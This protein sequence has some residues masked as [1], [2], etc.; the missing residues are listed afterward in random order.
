M[1][2]AL[3]PPNATQ[4]K[5][6]VAELIEQSTNL[7]VA[8]KYLWDPFKC[9]EKL[10]PWLAWAYSVDRWDPNWPINTQR[11][12]ISQS[13]E[14]HQ[15][16]GTPFAIQQALV[17]LGITAVQQEWWE[18][19]QNSIPGTFKVLALLNDNLTNGD[20][21]L[22]K[23]MLELVTEVIHQSKRGTAHFDVELGLKFDESNGLAAA[24]HS[25][26]SITDH[27]ITINGISPGAAGMFYSSSLASHQIIA[28]DLTFESEFRDEINAE[29]QAGVNGWA[30]NQVLMFDFTITGIMQ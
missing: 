21:I 23:E 17:S 2:K 28:A 4:F 1:M 8:I 12:V 16:K 7:E 10:L 6:D 30:T 20:G 15:H 29:I 11:N 5:K 9:P 18:L 27:E 25:S 26:T 22:N 3:L 19:N 24:P 14:V 13:F